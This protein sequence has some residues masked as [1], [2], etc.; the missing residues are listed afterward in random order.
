M[1]VFEVVE[2]NPASNWLHI[3]KI[4]MAEQMENEYKWMVTV[5]VMVRA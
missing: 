3:V 5:T 4:E 2:G 1:I